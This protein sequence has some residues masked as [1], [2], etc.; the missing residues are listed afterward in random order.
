MTDAAQDVACMFKLLVRYQSI[1]N[2]RQIKCLGSDKCSDN[3]KSE[4]LLLINSKHSQIDR[5][6]PGES[7][8]NSTLETVH[9]FQS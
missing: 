1:N 6:A 4:S 8:I 5:E 9:V 3:E 7:R 2:Y